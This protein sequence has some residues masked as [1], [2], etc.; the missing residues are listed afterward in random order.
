[1][2]IC[3]FGS[4][5]SEGRVRTWGVFRGAAPAI[6]MSWTLGRSFLH[7]KQRGCEEAASDSSSLPPYFLWLGMACRGHRGKGGQAE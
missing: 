5:S 6:G 3:E 1:M 4:I 2:R 7:G